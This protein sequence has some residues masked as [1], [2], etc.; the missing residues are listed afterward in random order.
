MRLFPSIQIMLKKTPIKD[1]D[2]KITGNEITALTVKNRVYPPFQEAT[3]CIDYMKGIQSYAGILDLAV[4]AGLVEKA[5]SWYSYD[6]DRL[7]Q[8]TDNATAALGK[9]PKLLEDINK[10]L[11]TT[12]YSNVNEQ[13]KAAN[14]AVDVVVNEKSVDGEDVEELPTFVEEPVVEE[15]VVEEKP[16][17]KRVS[18]KNKGV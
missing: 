8:G 6:G 1:A 15:P 10:W 13:L 17:K 11:E 9:Y 3:I 5:G 12:K 7:G 14:D 18:R 4:T 16:K 2:K